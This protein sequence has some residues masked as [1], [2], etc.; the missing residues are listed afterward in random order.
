[1]TSLTSLVPTAGRLLDREFPGWRDDINLT[2]L[3]MN[4]A[5]Y[6][7][8]VHCCCVAAQLG[9]HRY[10]MT[11][12]YE[13]EGYDRV[14]QHLA[15]SG[16]MTSGELSRVFGSGPELEQAWRSEI[17]PASTPRRIAV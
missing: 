17:A 13:A 3:D 4:N 16:G 8:G 11:G 2:E 1:M 9:Y 14:I 12:L 10:K 7:P 15:D 6:Q 5:S